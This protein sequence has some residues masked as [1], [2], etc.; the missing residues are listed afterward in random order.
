MVERVWQSVTG[1]RTVRTVMSRP[2]VLLLV[3]LLLVVVA[4][5]GAGAVETGSGVDPLSDGVSTSS[6]YDT[7]LGP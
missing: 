4:T 3:L 5:Q 1:S 7:S 2:R 6:D